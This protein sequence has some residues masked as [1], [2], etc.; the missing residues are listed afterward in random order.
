MHTPADDPVGCNRN[1]ILMAEMEANIKFHGAALTSNLEVWHKQIR[2]LAQ[3]DDI[4]LEAAH[5]AC[6]R[7]WVADN[8]S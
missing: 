2:I 1:S 5:E 7:A 8:S 6:P 4:V 3:G